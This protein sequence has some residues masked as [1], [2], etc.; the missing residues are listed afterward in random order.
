MKSYKGIQINTWRSIILFLMLIFLGGGDSFLYLDDAIKTSEMDNTENQKNA[1]YIHTEEELID[2]AMDVNE[3][4]PYAD[5]C[6]ILSEDL[7][8][9]GIDDF[10]PIGVYDGGC[11]FRGIFDGNG[12]TIRNLSITTT[13]GSGNNGLFGVLSGTICNLTMENCYV[14]G[15]ACGVFVVLQEAVMLGFIIA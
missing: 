12:H 2:F 4:N 1:I 15:N 13:E 14:A 3:G 6:V 5:M 11:Y 10:I 7:D 9:G 8:M